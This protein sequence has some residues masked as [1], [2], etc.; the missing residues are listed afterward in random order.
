MCFSTGFVCRKVT[1][2]PGVPPH[3]P[4]TMALLKGLLFSSGRGRLAWRG[5]AFSKREFVM[6]GESSPS[7]IWP[8]LTLKHRTAD[9]KGKKKTY[10]TNPKGR[11]AVK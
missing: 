10:I 3:P 4:P 11:E 8:L 7:R 2:E 6:E 5:E 1:K 9:K